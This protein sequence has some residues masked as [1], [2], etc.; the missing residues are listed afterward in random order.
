MNGRGS[1]PAA[2]ACV[3]DVIDRGRAR[4]AALAN[5]P[6]DPHERSVPS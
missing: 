5:V 6:N 2:M 4:R 3:F 1:D